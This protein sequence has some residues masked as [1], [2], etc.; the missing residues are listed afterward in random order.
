MRLFLA[1][2][3]CCLL[4][5]LIVVV[6]IPTVLLIGLILIL[7]CTNQCLQ[8]AYLQYFV[9][10]MFAM[11]LLAALIISYTDSFAH[12]Y[13]SD[14]LLYQSSVCLLRYFQ[15]VMLMFAYFCL[16]DAFDFS[17][18]LLLLLF[19]IVVILISCC[20]NQC[21]ILDVCL[22][23]SSHAWLLC[24]CLCIFVIPMIAYHACAAKLFRRWH[25]CLWLSCCFFHNL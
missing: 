6:L 8:F 20:A 21:L 19:L 2:D 14:A 25:A 18:W 10:L 15:V 3:C 9:M 11:L 12:R 5:L 1:G 17:W 23:C 24:L 7:C 4:L 22:T 16:V 13:Y